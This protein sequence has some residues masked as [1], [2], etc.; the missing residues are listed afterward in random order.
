MD[1]DLHPD[2]E[3]WDAVLRDQ[4]TALQQDWA[5]GSALEQIGAQVIRATCRDAGRLVA[6]AQITARK[7]GFVLSL[8]VCTRGPVWVGDVD[9][10]TKAATYRALK[11]KIQLSMPRAV[12]FTPDEVA[13]TGTKGLSRVM[14]GFSTVLLDLE[15]EPDALRKAFHGKWRNR[16]VA[17]EKSDLTI[18]QNGSKPAQYRWLLDTEEG[19]RTSRG[20]RAT[21]SDMVPAFVDARGDRNAVLILRADLG[22]EKTAAMMFLVHGARATYHMGWS[23][24]AGRKLGAHNLILW[25]AFPELRNRG[26]RQL[27]LGGVNT[28]TGAGIARFKIGT[29]GEVVTFAG[30]FF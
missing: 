22:R 8:A 28:T 3:T 7:I 17:A 10:A 23:N 20:Y 25:N 26:V 11:S 16:L 9:D 2:R 19:Q 24:E 4:P 18:R 13:K 1:I 15:Q 30:T 21:P 12:M 14:T 6:L 27:D 5:Y 29:G